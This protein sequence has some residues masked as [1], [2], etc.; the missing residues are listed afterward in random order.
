MTTVQYIPSEII[1]QIERNQNNFPNIVID[2]E[3]M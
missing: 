2:F 1:E 3:N